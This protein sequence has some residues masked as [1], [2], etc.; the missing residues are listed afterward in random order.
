MEYYDCHCCQYEDCDYCFAIIV[1]ILVINNSCSLFI[2]VV[3]VA[4]AA[5]LSTNIIV[6]VID[7]GCYFFSCYCAGDGYEL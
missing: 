5:K 3:V 2:V 4:A 6:I 1:T 7:C